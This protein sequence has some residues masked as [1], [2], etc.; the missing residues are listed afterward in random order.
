MRVL[1]KLGRRRLLERDRCSG[2]V[3]HVRPA[4]QA[5]KN[6]AVDLL[7]VRRFAQNQ[8]AARSAQRLVSCGRDNIE[9]RIERIT[10][11]VCRDQPADMGDVSHRQCAD[12]IGD[13]FERR[14]IIVTWVRRITTKHDF[15]S[16]RLCDR[17]K[18]VEIDSTALLRGTFV[19]HEVEYLAHVRNR[20]SMRQVA[21]MRQVHR[22]H[23]VAGI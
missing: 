3:V 2:D 14:V 9:T 16:G 6:R 8:S 15:R 22:Q 1:D 13:L 12:F 4:L 20:R 17:H 11:D 7:R 10:H 5:W 18:R 23:R 21:A 19:T